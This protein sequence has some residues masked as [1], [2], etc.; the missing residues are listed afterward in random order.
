M[1][2]SVHGTILNSLELKKKLNFTLKI[3]N[4]KERLNFSISNP[5]SRFY[6]KNEEKNI[7][8][9]MVA[10]LRSCEQKI[11][12]FTIIY[13]YHNNNLLKIYCVMLF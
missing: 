10:F 6:H 3:N 8:V 4:F 12:M 5:L 11:S 1:N 9:I 13:K 2:E 7:S